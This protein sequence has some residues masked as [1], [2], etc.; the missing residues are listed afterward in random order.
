[1][2]KFLST[3]ST[4]A[5]VYTITEDGKRIKYRTPKAHDDRVELLSIA[6]SDADMRLD[7]AEAILT[8]SV[9]YLAFD[10]NYA[11]SLS[12]RKFRRHIPNHTVKSKLN[13]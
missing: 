11:D 12:V 2:K 7:D 9:N 1:M 6:V 3:Y 10:T 13:K 4:D 5:V 8:E